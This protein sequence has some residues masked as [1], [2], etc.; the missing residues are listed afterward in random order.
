MK[1]EARIIGPLRQYFADE[2]ACIDL[3]DGTTAADLL[4]RMNPPPWIGRTPLLVVLNQ[5]FV[6]PSA[7]LHEGD[8]VRFMLPVGG[9]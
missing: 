1:V 2:R 7:L 3:P 4:S 6:R 8:R 9:G 5:R